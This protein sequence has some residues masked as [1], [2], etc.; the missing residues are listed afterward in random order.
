M[1]KLYG[2]EMS[3]N[4]YK[5]RLLL[6]LLKID[7]EWIKV[8]LMKGE[9]KSPEYLK[10][11]S[12]GQVYL[13]RQY[14]GEKWLP[15]DALPL[16]Q[17][18]RWLSTTAGEVRQGLENARLYYLFGATNINIER[19]HQKA[20]YILTQLDQH[21][22]THTWLEFERPTIADI[23]V[24]P[25]VAL[26]RDGKIELDAYPHVIAWSDRVQQLPGYIPMLG[27]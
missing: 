25:Y 2:H 14:G 15:L 9:Q 8:D 10:L 18:V 5:V 16:A 6:E 22:S 24:F 17:V 19:A 23:A 26:A 1:I 27:I 12:F 4:S 20:K 7:Y 3:G 11:N 13:A 21:L